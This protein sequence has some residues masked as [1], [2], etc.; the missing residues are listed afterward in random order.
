MRPSAIVFCFAAVVVTA[1]ASYLAFLP[2]SSGTIAFWVFSA[3]PTLMFGGLG[4][5]WASRE[6][7]LREWITPQ[8]G[9]FT[10]GV[11]GAA[12]LYFVAWA[13][14]H[15]V[16]P[17]GSPREIWLASLY[18]EIGDP[19]SLRAHGPAIAATIAG[20][21]F[22]EEVLWR[23]VVTQLVAERVGSRTAWI[24]AAGLYALAYVPTAW[25]LKAASGLGGGLNPIV[26]MAALGSG[27]LWGAMAR[28]F[29][30]LTPGVLAHAL[31]DWIVVMM[32]PFWGAGRM[33]QS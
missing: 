33:F 19:R 29:G 15:L 28:F 23:G 18:G 24:W 16:A 32:F 5:M 8:W 4:A 25:S 17:I 11:C 21:A 3:G 6:D 31:F 10:R 30:R 27:L 2:E 9:D 22:A 14:V 1:V 13:F 20:A 7:L 26:P 12:L